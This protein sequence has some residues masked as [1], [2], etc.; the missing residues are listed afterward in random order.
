[1]TDIVCVGD[2]MVECI[3]HDA[4][5]PGSNATLVVDSP[6]QVVGGSAFN[7]CWTLA[8]LG[9]V[10]RLV[11]PFGDHQAT[12]VREAFAA[13]KLPRAGLIETTGD[14]DLLVVV[15]REGAFR[16]VY[17]REPLPERLAEAVR[18]RV[19]R[20]RCLLLIG[21]RHPALRVVALEI[22]QVFA[23][24][25]V[26]FSPGYAIYEYPG[27][28]LRPLV[29]RADLTIVNRNE[30]EYLQRTLGAAT[31][32]ELAASL[33]GL[34]IVTLAHEGARLFEGRCVRE[35]G[36]YARS[37][38]DAI[39]AGDAFLA[40]FLVERLRGADVDTAARFAAMCGA[41]VADAARVRVALD[42]AT[43]R[44]LLR[45]HPG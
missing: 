14:T 28:E 4:P 2:L 24:E 37:T 1:M 32:D 18:E 25:L 33:R 44:C 8:H 10:P 7:T 16:S 42:A 35:Y 9:H 3:V 19:G 12:I 15:A 13:A 6:G 17:L 11:A 39:G 45:E 22:A 41:Y 43:I 20:P 34:V 31:T 29:E 30:A 23:G 21:T 38:V 5:W 26:V 40:G 36:S 27:D